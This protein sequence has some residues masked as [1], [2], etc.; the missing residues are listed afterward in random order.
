VY[1]YA[2]AGVY[3]VHDTPYALKALWHLESDPGLDVSRSLG[4]ESFA[5][6]GAADANEPVFRDANRR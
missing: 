1:K 5:R 6:I 2:Q 3:S 4:R